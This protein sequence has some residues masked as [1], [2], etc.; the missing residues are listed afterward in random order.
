MGIGFKKKKIR[1]EIKKPARVKGSSG[2]AR[3][4]SQRGIY[5]QLEMRDLVFIVESDI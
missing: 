3:Q 2:P 5:N 1:K 4:V